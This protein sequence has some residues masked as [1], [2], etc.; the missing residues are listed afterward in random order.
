MPANG[1]LADRYVCT[2]VRRP[3]PPPPPWHHTPLPGGA[4][5]ARPPCPPPQCDVACAT[6]VGPASNDCAP[7]PD[8]NTITCADNFYQ[9]NIT[10]GSGNRRSLLN[11][12]TVEV[13][14]TCTE[15]SVLRVVHAYI[16]WRAWVS[17]WW[18]GSSSGRAGG[19]LNGR[20]TDAPPRPACSAPP[21]PSARALRPPTSACPAATLRRSA[22]CTR[23]SPAS[24]A[25]A[26]PPTARRRARRA[27][28]P[29]TRSALLA[30]AHRPRPPR[31]A[32]T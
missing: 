29:V 11:P 12:I 28:A 16:R 32:P 14:T 4:P 19:F 1:T 27:P 3:R 2:K 13:A 31:A 6:C 17:Q 9:T 23:T 10:Y 7:R 18:G 30:G 24:R 8:N 21:S 26:A 20:T 25:T 15:A 22:A 5:D